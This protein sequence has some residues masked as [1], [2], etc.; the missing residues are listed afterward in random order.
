MTTQQTTSTQAAAPAL[1]ASELALQF[2]Q[3]VLMRDAIILRDVF[4]WSKEE[5]NSF[6]NEQQFAAA[7]KLV[8]AGNIAIRKVPM[9][10]AAIE[11]SAKP[12]VVAPAKAPTFQ[13]HTRPPVA[14]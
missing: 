10:R 1:M 13:M 7:Q 6:T 4:H 2:Y 11:A 14:A 8:S 9:T 12:T 3:A 5:L